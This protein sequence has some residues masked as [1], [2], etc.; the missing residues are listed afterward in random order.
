M[1]SPLT[2]VIP[3]YNEDKRL[4]SEVF[5]SH[6]DRFPIPHFIFVDD[7][8]TD[9]T[10]AMLEELSLRGSGRI[11]H[12]SLNH[13]KGKAEAVRL[14]IQRALSSGAANVGYWDADLS[15]PLN[16]IERFYE[17]L[18]HNR[19]CIIICGSR[20]KRLGA[21]ID[22]HWYR[23]YPG[24]II[25]TLI[26]TSLHLPIY[27]SQCG[28]KIFTREIAIPLFEEPFLSPWLFDVELFARTI[29]ILGREQTLRSVYEIP[30]VSWCDIG[31]SKITPTYIPKIP[32]ELLRIRIHYRQ[33]LRKL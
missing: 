27:D 8:S 21:T 30:L 6:L 12:I 22:R 3:C 31:E 9:S 32:F 20:I 19:D 28:A 1:S 25:A 7:G 23:H 5:I 10:L 16:E 17:R 26:G 33:E 15:T 13:N 2:I 24:R 29:G 11:T 14:G 4:Q 18:N